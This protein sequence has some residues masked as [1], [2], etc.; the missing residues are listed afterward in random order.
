M[1]SLFALQPLPTGSIDKRYGGCGPP[2]VGAFGYSRRS[3]ARVH[4]ATAMPMSGM[5]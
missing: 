4:R 1:P 5:V 3:R 2:L